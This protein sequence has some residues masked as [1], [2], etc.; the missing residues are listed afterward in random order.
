MDKTKGSIGLCSR[1]G[2]TA[3]V[4]I[5]ARKLMQLRDVENCNNSSHRS[6]R[7]SWAVKGWWSKGSDHQSQ[8]KATLT[9]KNE[10]EGGSCWE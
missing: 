9:K 7:S 8:S 3:S 6:N 10:N 1:E 2:L 5:A 4:I